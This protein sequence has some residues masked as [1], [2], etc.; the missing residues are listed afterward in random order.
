[1][2]WN[3]GYTTQILVRCNSCVYNDDLQHKQAQANTF[4]MVMKHDITEAARVTASD[5]RAAEQ[6]MSQCNSC[7]QTSNKALYSRWRETHGEQHKS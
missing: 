6:H 3:A 1:M 4:A 7:K 5:K 2:A